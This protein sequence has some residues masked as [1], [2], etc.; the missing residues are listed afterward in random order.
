[1]STF[2]RYSIIVKIC[3]Y[4]TVKQKNIIKAAKK[5]CKNKLQI[6]IKNCLM[7]KKMSK[8]S[9]EETDIKILS[10]QDKQ[11]LRKYLKN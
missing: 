10:E 1:M 5:D 6:N 2:F 7:K 4:L 11:K 9:M 3:S 8:E